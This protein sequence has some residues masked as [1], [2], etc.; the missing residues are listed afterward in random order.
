MWLQ[1]GG[2]AI[3]RMLLSIINLF[4]FQTVETLKE[5][6]ELRRSPRRPDAAKRMVEQSEVIILIGFNLLQ[7]VQRL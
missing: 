3:M 7:E 5:M 1:C 6:K 2:M 4:H